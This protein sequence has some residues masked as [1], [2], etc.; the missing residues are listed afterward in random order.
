MHDP[1]HL[2]KQVRISLNHLA[3][4]AISPAS[5]IQ[6]AL[7]D[8]IKNTPI[9]FHNSVVNKLSQQANAFY[10]G[11]SKIPE[12]NALQPQAALYT[13][14]GVNVD[15]FRTDSGIKDCVTFANQ[16]LKDQGVLVLPGK[17]F[18]IVGARWMPRA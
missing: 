6:C 5:I 15:R 14:V 3:T 16:L 8:I 1:Y 17:I 7:P 4:L 18:G 11:V 13:M 2:L 9:S 12:L 10:E